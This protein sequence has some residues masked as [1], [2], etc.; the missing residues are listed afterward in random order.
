MKR[1]FLF[2]FAFGLLALN[3]FAVGKWR[4]ELTK[5]D[6]L[7]GWDADFVNYIYEDSIGYFVCRS[8][9][10][11]QFFIISREMFDTEVQAGRIGALVRVGIYDDYGKLLDHFD[12]WLGKKNNRGTKLGTYNLGYMNNPTGQDTKVR[13]VMQTLSSPGGYMR[14]VCYTVDDQRFDFRVYPNPE[15]FK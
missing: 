1:F 12:M 5:A 15:W 6:I 10:T 3:T 14:F 9:Q 7:L 4:T 13:K 2:F 8:D 11:D